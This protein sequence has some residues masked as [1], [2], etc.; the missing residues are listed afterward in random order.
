MKTLNQIY[1]TLKGYKIIGYSSKTNLFGLN[2]LVISVFY[3]VLTEAIISHLRRFI[4]N[5]FADGLV[6]QLV[7]EFIA[8]AELCATCFELIIVADNYG[9]VMYGLFLFLL[10]VW[11][12]FN[13]E[14]SSACP[15]IPIEEIFE[16]KRNIFIGFLVIGAQI[17]GGLSIF[18]YIQILWSL[19]LVET[20]QGRAFEEC[21]T[22]LQVSVILGSIIEGIATC[23][24][25]IFSRI[26]GET[27]SRMGNILDAFIGTLMVVAAFN[28]SGGYFN[29]ALATSL[30]YGCKGNTIPE[31]MLVYW[32]GPTIGAIFSVFIF[33]SKP[34]QNIVKILTGKRD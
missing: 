30:K 19:E 14:D 3:I 22:D 18:R 21:S 15:Y 4:K 7:L 2:P 29:P 1:K 25:R 32:L 28:Y 26:L 6:R 5:S 23:I 13:W 27:N 33:N 16:R 20:H 8:T 24:C 9:V 12:S 31:H 11:W 17:L 10:T 34:I